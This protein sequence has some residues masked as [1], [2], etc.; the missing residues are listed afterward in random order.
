MLILNG[1]SFNQSDYIMHV[2]D[3]KIRPHLMYKY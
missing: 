3:T 1:K 2:A